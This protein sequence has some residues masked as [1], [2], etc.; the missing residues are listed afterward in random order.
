[1]Y[2]QEGVHFMQQFVLCKSSSSTCKNLMVQEEKNGGR[3]TESKS[4]NI[5]VCCYTDV[6]HLNLNLGKNTKLFKIYSNILKSKSTHYASL[7][8]HILFD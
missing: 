1:M 5:A 8:N 2:E 3:C 7:Q 6:L 4:S